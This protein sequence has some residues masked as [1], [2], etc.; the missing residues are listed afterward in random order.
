MYIIIGIVALGLPISTVSDKPCPEKYRRLSLEHSFCKA[1]N[2][3]CKFVSK[4]VNEQEKAEILNIHN[5]FRNKVAMGQETRAG[6]LPAAANMHAITWD[7]ELAAIAQKWAEQCV[8]DHDCKEC[9][10]TMGF[11]VGQNVGYKWYSCSGNCNIRSADWTGKATDFYEKEINDYSKEL[12]KKHPANYPKI[13]GHTTQVIWAR[14]H[15]I[16]CGFSS[17]EGAN[18][19]RPGIIQ[20]YVCNY[21]PAGNLRDFPVYLEG[22]P[23]SRCPENSCCGASCNKDFP[24]LCFISGNAPLEPQPPGLLYFCN[25]QK[26]GESCEFDSEGAGRWKLFETSGGTFLSVVVQ[27]GKSS[28]VR[29]RPVIKVKRGSCMTIYLRKGPNVFGDKE[30]CNI[31]IEIEHNGQKSTESVWTYT[32]KNFIKSPVQMKYDGDIK[33]ALKMSVPANAAA[34]FLDLYQIEISEAGCQRGK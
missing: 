23:C 11:S 26:D 22:S 8:N 27:P 12:V 31:E 14:T 24:G 28:T 34:Q 13:I 16:G 4:G 6:G 9:R 25:F 29:F 21:G 2:S 10:A 18:N 1:S 33:F 20:I 15:K 32:S 5:M 17:F 7:N 3:S 30:N 19:G